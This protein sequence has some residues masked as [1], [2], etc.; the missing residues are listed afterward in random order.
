MKALLI[1]NPGS[2]AGRGKK[3][4]PLWKA[5]L[6]KHGIGFDCFQTEAPGQ[7][8]EVV[9]N[10][11]DYDTVVAVGGDG[12]INE[13]ID[14]LMQREHSDLQMGVLYSGTSPDFCR[15]HAIPLEVSRAVDVLA[16]GK[17]TPVDIVRI[18]C[19][20]ADGSE[21]ISHF[22][23]SCNIGL[24][25]CIART[26]NRVRKVFGDTAGTGLA[27][28]WS[29]FLLKPRNLK[30]TVDCQVIELQAVNN[31][32]IIKNPFLASGLRLDLRLQPADGRLMLFAVYDKSRLSLLSML[33]GFYS[34]RVAE[35]SDVFVKQVTTVKVECADPCAVEFD[36][37]PRG[38]LP[39]EV[40]LIPQGLN[41]IGS[42]ND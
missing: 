21:R 41:L 25:G 16:S 37:D 42:T 12:T 3:L 31:L 4:W 35:R 17:T 40:K 9:K 2:R 26:S 34:G 18:R 10:L 30:L 7:A 28:L 38:F 15:F 8:V 11:Q 39:I 24:G 13:V 33:P 32:G 29:I 22:A 19:R 23:S 36:G 6:R 20:S 27:V 5:E 14:G 1:M